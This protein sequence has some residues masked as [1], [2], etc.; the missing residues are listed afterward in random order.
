MRSVKQVKKSDEEET[1]NDWNER[2][3]EFVHFLKLQKNAEKHRLSASKSLPA[4][5][6]EL[7]TIRRLYAAVN[8][9]IPLYSEE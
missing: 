6:A 3:N 4:K 5:W 1:Q 8:A 9:K 2:I 7:A